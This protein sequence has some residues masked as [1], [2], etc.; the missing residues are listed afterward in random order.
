[1]SSLEPTK[2]EKIRRL[3]WAV[4]SDTLSGVYATLVLGSV[5]ILYL[6]EMGLA[7][8]QIGV[9]QSLLH[10]VGPF[11]LFLAPFAAR[12]GYKRTF[13]LFYG[14]R[15]L[16]IGLL[17]AAPWMSVHYGVDGVFWLVFGTMSIYSVCRVIGEI[18]IY[19]WRHEFVPDAVR[20]KLG[21]ITTILNTLMA[22]GSVTFASYI[23]RQSEDLGRFQM[24][25]AIGIVF[26]IASVLTK[27][28]LPGG[29]P[30]PRQTSDSPHRRLML[31]TLKDKNFLRYLWG[32]SLISLGSGGWGV[33]VP[34]YLKDT[35]GLSAGDVVFLQT[36]SMLG[37]LAF[38]YLLGWAADRY[39]SKPVLLTGLILTLILP[40]GWLF[41]P[42]ESVWSETWG[43]VIAFVAG[44]ASIGTSLGSGRLLYVSVVP[45]AKKTEYMAVYYSWIEIFGIMSPVLAGV[46]LDYLQ[47]ASGNG[48]WF[49][50]YTPF[51]LVGL[52]LTACSIVLF[53]GIH[54]PGAAPVRDFWRLFVEGNP[55]R[56]FGSMMGHTWVREES[57][58]VVATERMGASRS[59]LTVQELVEA[60]EDPSFNVRYEAVIAIARTRPD[61]RLV[62][63][64]V[65]ILRGDEP[66]LS[67]AAAW[68]LGRLGDPLAIPALREA[69]DSDYPLL[70]S[71]S[72]RAL[73]TLGDEKSA[74][75]FLDRFQETDDPGMRLAYG[76]SLGR[77]GCREAAN[78][79]MVFMDSLE[80]PSARREMA[81]ALACLV[82][83]ERR[84]VRLWRRL[85]SD[86]GTASSQ[87]LFAIQRRFHR[88]LPQ[89]DTVS[90]VMGGSEQKMA[91][92]DLDQGVVLLSWLIVQ[93]MGL[94]PDPPQAHAS[95][96]QS[97]DESTRIVL[98][99][100]ATGLDRFGAS[101]PEYL[102]LALHALDAALTR[103]EKT[104]T[105]TDV[106]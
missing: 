96:E 24:L 103:M 76:L 2:S 29:A 63:A 98:E 84:F 69:L 11:G 39:G 4:C 75:V 30:S 31:E 74:P 97:I 47:E 70:A 101:R 58:R 94:I 59:R 20:G 3:P 16:V 83:D 43:M 60:L 45:A 15:K 44:T 6:D 19:P 99:G 54:D 37:A 55:L 95:Q 1:M 64:L 26:G 73:A 89:E 5:F 82:G 41:M 10:L 65:D 92:A 100:C 48:A 52:A 13:L 62:Q 91:H 40:V 53:R 7:K 68:A 79:L 57:A 71:R 61:G 51:F 22:L 9:L 35:V 72:A 56:A 88:F 90:A 33:F 27:A 80:K 77:L 93:F 34:L 28:P 87:T 14:S 104:R 81:L 50:P 32:L 67:V 18:A 78:E 105:Q 17:I 25:I 23:I 36:G 66:D 12:F 46:A 8:T 38:S 86:P 49:D 106:G 85:R 21:A 102:A 42:R